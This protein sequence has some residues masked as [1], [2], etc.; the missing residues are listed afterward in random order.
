MEKRFLS[1]AFALLSV[2]FTSCNNENEVIAVSNG[3]MN[4]TAHIEGASSTRA[5]KFDWKENDRLGVFVCAGTIDKPYLG[6]SDRYTNVLFKHNGKGFFAQ[7]VYLD[8]NPAEVFAYYPYEVQ[9]STGTAIP[10]ESTT[11]TDYLY[12]HSDTP[13][14]IT[15]KK[16]VIKMNHALSQVVFRLRKAASY[17][18][19]ACLLQALTIEN[20]DANNVFKTAG[21]LDLGTG[22]IIG[23]STDGVLALMPGSSLLL[24]E[25]YQN[26]SSICF[27]VTATAGKNIKAVFTIDDR[28]FRYEFPAGT[29]WAPGYRN[30]YTLTVTNSSVDIGGD[31]SGDGTSDD[32]ITIEPW[33][34]NKDSDISLVPI[35]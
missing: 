25:D 33:A 30:I 16:V 14:S 15:Q 17:N 1:A 11:Q 12:G 4:I 27:P 28:Q 18:E 5:E 20:N 8:E 23:T 35:L 29:T 21:T 9:N 34:D 31:G 2:A 6:N 22:N 7:H 13:A 26:V 19:G 3:E 32:G 24:T 10:I